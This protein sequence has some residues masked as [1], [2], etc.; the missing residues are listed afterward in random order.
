[1]SDALP[2]VPT[3]RSSDLFRLLQRLV[4]RTADGQGQGCSQCQM[5]NVKCQMMLPHCSLCVLC[6]S[7][8]SPVPKAQGPTPNADHRPPSGSRSEEHTSE[9]QLPC[10]LV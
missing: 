1:A 9:L 4:R 5:S 3:R 2:A 6:V 8:V 7:A 10:N